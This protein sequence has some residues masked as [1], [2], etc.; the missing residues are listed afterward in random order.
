MK[1]VF[2]ITPFLLLLLAGHFQ[3]FRP[4]V[5]TTVYARTGR[6]GADC[7][8]SGICTISSSGGQAPPPPG[9]K[10]AMGYNSQGQVF[11]EFRYVDLPN[12]IVASQFGADAFE[13]QSDYPVPT[14][15]LQ[16]INA[17]DTMLILKAGFYPLNKS[18]Q[19]VRITF[20]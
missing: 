7:T 4:E 20:N 3:T 15:V 13:M 1:Q 19:A 17:K 8:G 12:E 9:Y 6:H 10:A 11:L 18:S 5:T 16:A 2:V 14:S